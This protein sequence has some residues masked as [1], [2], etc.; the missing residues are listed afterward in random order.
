ME[1]NEFNDRKYQSLVHRSRPLKY[2]DSGTD[3]QSEKEP[4]FPKK[5]SKPR[6]YSGK[7][8][9]NTKYTTPGVYYH[10]FRRVASIT[11]F[12]ESANNT[13]V[14]TQVPWKALLLTVILLSLGSMSISTSAFLLFGF[15]PDAVRISYSSVG[16]K[17]D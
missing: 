15:S 17:S 1:S 11:C 8:S 3:H 12:Y 14:Y 2:A 7:R 16:L 6:S 13:S 10:L 9:V 4:L 5:A